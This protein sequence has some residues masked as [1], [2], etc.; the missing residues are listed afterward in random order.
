MIVAADYSKIGRESF[1]YIDEAA[2]AD[3]LITNSEAARAEL[4][5]LRELVADIRLV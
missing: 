5:V 4:D 2:R 1:S 3:V